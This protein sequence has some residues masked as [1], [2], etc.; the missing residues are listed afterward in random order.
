[1]LFDLLEAV[2]VV[3]AAAAA[4]VLAATAAAAATA[5]KA[6]GNAVSWLAAVAATAVVQHQQAKAAQQVGL[7]LQQWQ[8]VG[9]AAMQVWCRSSVVVVTATEK[10]WLLRGVV[11][12]E[13]VEVLRKNSGFKTA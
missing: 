1:M 11:P 12:K 7:A 10:L 2:V 13:Q 8:Q 3:A 6:A 4:V 9:V 5:G